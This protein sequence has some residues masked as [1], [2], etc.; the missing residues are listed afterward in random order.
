MLASS[1]SSRSPARLHHTS[2]CHFVVLLVHGS[3]WVARRV[4]RAQVDDLVARPGQRKLRPGVAGPNAGAGVLL[5]LRVARV[6]E[7]SLV[8]EGFGKLPRVP[9]RVDRIGVGE[10]GP[11]GVPRSGELRPA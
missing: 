5:S 11:A 9:V 1:R 8:G 4:G 3:R 2:T 6:V 7:L 10:G